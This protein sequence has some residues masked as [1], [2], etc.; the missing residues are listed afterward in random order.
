MAIFG[1]VSTVRAQCAALRYFDPAFAY[2]DEILR[3]GSE[4]NQR[5]HALAAGGVNRV[6]L[7]GE[8]YAME[9]V[10]ET[11][12]RTKGLFE[13]HRRFIDVQVVVAGDEIMEVVEI[14]LL[15]PKTAYDAEKDFLLYGDFAAASVLRFRAGEAAV[16]FPKDGHM[17]SLRAGAAAQLVRKT[18]VKVPV[19]A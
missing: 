18:V 10:Y 15:P 13:S 16:F 2:I 8:M 4:A 6:E 5:L 19:P 7:G 9:Q 14:G 1:S 17:P 3:P 11:K 12:E